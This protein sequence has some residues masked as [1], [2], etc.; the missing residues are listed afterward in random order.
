MRA[1]AMRMTMQEPSRNIEVEQVEL[2]RTRSI[3]RRWT[4][5]TKQNK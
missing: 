2:D 4:R 1:R 5:W 3:T